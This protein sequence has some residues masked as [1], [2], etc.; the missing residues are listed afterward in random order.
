MPRSQLAAET[1]GDAHALDAGR[2][3]ASLV[4]SAWRLR[5]RTKAALDDDATGQSNDG[6]EERLREV[7]SRAGVLINELARPALFLNLPVEPDAPPHLAARRTRL[8]FSATTGSHAIF[9]ASRWAQ[10]LRV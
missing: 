2:P 10:C 9:L 5:E 1:L 3:V 4:L 8:P 7:W 6:N